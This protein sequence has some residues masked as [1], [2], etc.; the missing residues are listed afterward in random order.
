MSLS[1]IAYTECCICILGYVLEKGLSQKGELS[2]GT[3]D[4]ECITPGEEWSLDTEVLSELP[5]DI[6][7]VLSVRICISLF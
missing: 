3:F 5:H 7:M 4:D 1:N 6:T 2:Q